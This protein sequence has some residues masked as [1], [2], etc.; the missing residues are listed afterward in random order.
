VVVGLAGLAGITTLIKHAR[1]CGVGNSISVLLKQAT[2]MFRLATAVD[3][4]EVLLGLA[5]ARQA[6]TETAISRVHFFPFGAFEA[7]ARFAR[8]LAE[9]RF[10]IVD[11]ERRIVVNR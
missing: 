2:N 1:N 6:D 3:P 9:G 4:S 5:H 7:T 11:S 10:E 8:A